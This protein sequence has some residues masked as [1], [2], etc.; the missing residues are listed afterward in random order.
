MHQREKACDMRQGNNNNDNNN[1]NKA[2]PITGH[3]GPTGRVEV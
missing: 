2:H 3:E 1:N